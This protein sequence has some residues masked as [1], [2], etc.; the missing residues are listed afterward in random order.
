MLEKRI[1]VYIRLSSAD[2][3]TGSA[4]DESNSVKGQRNIIN[5][6]LDNHSELSN[7]PRTEFV[8][9]GFTGTNTNRP[10]F[11]RMIA[12]IKAGKYFCCITKDFSRFSRDYIEW[13]DYLEYLFPFLGVRYISINDNYD[14]SDYKGTTGGIDVIM[15]AIIYDA[16]SKDLSLKVKSGKAQARKKG[17]RNGFPAYGYKR[18]PHQKAMDIIDPEAAVI[19]RRIFNAA[20]D[21]M[22]IGEIAKMLND[23]N[24]PTP[25]MYFRMKNPEN[26][27]F[28]TTSSKQKWDYGVVRDILNRYTYTGATVGG[29]REQVFPCKRSYVKKS[30]EEWIIVPNMHEAI[31]TTEEYELA[32]KIIKKRKMPKKKLTLFPLKSLVICANC[33][34]RMDKTPS[35]VFLCKY[36]SH[37]GDEECKNSHIQEPK[38]EQI[39]FQ[40]I[41]KRIEVWKRENKSKQKRSVS[42][43]NNNRKN[44]EK[45]NRRIEFLKRKKF[46]EYEQYTLGNISKEIYLQNK[47]NIDV[48]MSRLQLE[49]EEI[50]NDQ[51]IVS[52]DFNIVSSEI[53]DICERFCNEKSLTYD[54]AHAFINRILVYPNERI[55]IEWRYESLFS[56]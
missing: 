37:E 7:Y 28:L 3:D 54:M 31:I 15:R 56:K 8:D 34:R 25:S 14:S 42:S 1:A 4:K 2:E 32:Q 11:Q 48:E 50:Q 51:N 24:I 19:V 10:A 52:T 9:D 33:L 12:D 27:K 30:R 17:R 22:K 47:R 5:Y 20:I 29:L 39:V 21:G 13:G 36:R 26:R 6:F 53:E 38:L 55:E 45:L 23:E 40:A 35:N 44:L 46:R 43:Q 49:A 41:C 18:D 16:Y